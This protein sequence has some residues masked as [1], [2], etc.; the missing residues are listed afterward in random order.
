MSDVRVRPMTKADL[1]PVGAL[2]GALVRQHHAYDAD[3]FF[4]TPEVEEGYRWWFS[5]QLGQG[6]VVLLVAEVDGSVAGYLYA[7]LE[8]RDWAMLLDEHGAL[9]DV[10]VDER[11]R[12]RGVARALV[13]AGVT[14][15]EQ[16]GARRVVLS[17]AT[18]NREAQALF[19]S[20]GF[21]ATMVE[22]TR[23]RPG[24]ER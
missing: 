3:R 5:K 4:L 24:A 18:Q 23:S 15:L 10:F 13:G 20:L 17:S 14:A 16:L 11:F 9:H 22:M 7:S 2:A 6:G 19:A 8:E 12:R 1:E 21:R